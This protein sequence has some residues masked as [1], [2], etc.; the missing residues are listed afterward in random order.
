MAVNM[1]SVRKEEAMTS[2]WELLNREAICEMTMAVGWRGANRRRN[3]HEGGEMAEYQWW[4]CLEEEEGE[5][6]AQWAMSYVMKN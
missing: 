3:G 2:I 1:Y 4:I 5:W 6:Q